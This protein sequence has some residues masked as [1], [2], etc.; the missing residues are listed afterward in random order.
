M[1]QALAS[2]RSEAKRR[3]GVVGRGLQWPVA[4]RRFIYG[5]G[6][7]RLALRLRTDSSAVCWGGEEK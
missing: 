1:P 6:G 4:L 2:L 5:D 3:C 7:G